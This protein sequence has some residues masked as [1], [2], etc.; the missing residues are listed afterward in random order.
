MF[1]NLEYLVNAKYSEHVKYLVGPCE[2]FGPC[3]ILGECR[4][5]I[6]RGKTRFLCQLRTMPGA[7]SVTNLTLPRDETAEEEILG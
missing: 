7:G 6:A 5:Q 2:T 4:P 3:G 1:A